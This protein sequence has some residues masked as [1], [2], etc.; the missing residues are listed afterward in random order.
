MEMAKMTRGRCVLTY[1]IAALV[2]Y[3]LDSCD[4]ADHPA[5]LDKTMGLKRRLQTIWREAGGP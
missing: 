2:A 5:L 4:Q 1:S 3:S